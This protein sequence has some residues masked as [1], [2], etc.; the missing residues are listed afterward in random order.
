MVLPL[1]AALVAAAPAAA[2]SAAVG[3][4]PAPTWQTNGHVETVTMVGTVAYLGG[5]FTSVRP[6]GDPPGTGEV[7]RSHAAAINVSTGDVL[8]WDPSPNG[9][10]RAIVV[11]GG[12]A[13]LGGS[14]SAAGGAPAGNLAAVDT[15]A[16]ARVSGWPGSANAQVNALALRA[17]VLFAGGDF[18]RVNSATRGSLAALDVST[19]RLV[20]GW[21][22][23]TNGHVKALALTADGTRLIAGG[24]F[25]T[26]DGSAH[27]SV[28]AVSPAT[29]RVVPWR[30]GVSFPVVALAADASAVYIAGGG[31]GGNFLAVDPVRGTMRWRG[32]TN[33]NAQAV[34]S[35]GGMVVVGG[36]F[37][38]YCGPVIGREVC[39]TGHRR[40]K[41]LAVN[42]RTGALMSWNPG[43]NSPLGVFGLASDATGM[44]VVGDF[45]VLGGAAQQGLGLLPATS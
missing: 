17:G 43:A 15:N 12:V 31:N 1:T 40:L 27:A 41:L 19:G 6:A 21:R 11:S 30:G 29:A 38:S 37:T 4:T 3:T 34:A 10:V 14:F 28:V 7:P 25:T 33:G 22:A 44:A 8:P 9:D 39:T 42:A 32:G 13:Y 45:T 36:H 24:S 2:A 20:A 18:S 26:V 35:D 5:T 23:D 16:G